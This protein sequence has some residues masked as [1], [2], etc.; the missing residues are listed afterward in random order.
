MVREKA[1]SD[2][3]VSTVR[4]LVPID[5]AMFQKM[6]EDVATCQEIISTIPYEPVKESVVPQNTIAN[7]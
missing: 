1:F 6:C 7:L 3:T 4:R 5:D 2:A